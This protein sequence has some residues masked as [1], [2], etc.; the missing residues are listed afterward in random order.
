M[1]SGEVKAA[2]GGSV[3][4]NEEGRSS[5][6]MELVPTTCVHCLMILPLYSLGAPSKAALLPFPTRNG[7]IYEVSCGVVSRGRV[8]VND[9]ERRQVQ[10]CLY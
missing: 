2:G 8:E 1:E 7:N 10:W 3:I 4:T 5:R 9:D 6:F